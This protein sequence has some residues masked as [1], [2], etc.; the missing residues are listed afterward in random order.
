MD[1]TKNYDVLLYWGSP[2]FIRTLQVDLG[3]KEL[4]L[5]FFIIGY[6]C[7]VDFRISVKST[8]ENS[9]ILE[10]C[11]DHLSKPSTSGTVATSDIEFL[12]MFSIEKTYII[13]DWIGQ[14]TVISMH[15]HGSLDWFCQDSLVQKMI[16]R[17][18]NNLVDQKD[19]NVN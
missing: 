19:G 6:I 16:S 5:C 10:P 7:Q 18:Q 17:M 3:L 11:K 14:L 15:N 2:E 4:F 13:C 1:F 8:N 9:L 12:T